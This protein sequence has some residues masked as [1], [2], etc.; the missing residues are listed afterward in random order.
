M[1]RKFEVS[2]QFDKNNDYCPW[3]S[4]YIYDHISFDS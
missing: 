1:A 3:G 4:V 2:L